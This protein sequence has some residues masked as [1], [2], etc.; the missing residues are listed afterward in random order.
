MQGWY[1]LVQKPCIS[2]VDEAMQSLLL[3]KDLQRARSVEMIDS[4]M[5]W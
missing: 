2:S 1:L 3:T 5:S 4:G